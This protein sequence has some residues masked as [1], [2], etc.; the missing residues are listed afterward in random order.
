MQV[1]RLGGGGGLDTS[2]NLTEPKAKERGGER[3][4]GGRR[5]R[6]LVV[7]VLVVGMVV[8]MWVGGWVGG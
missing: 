3:G 4:V 1:R 7:L 6:V 2:P 8:V 5:R